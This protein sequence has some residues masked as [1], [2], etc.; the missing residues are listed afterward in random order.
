MRTTVLSLFYDESDLSPPTGTALEPR[1]GCSGDLYR[2]DRLTGRVAHLRH[3]TN[4]TLTYL[5][6]ARDGS[7][8]VSAENCGR[9][10]S[11]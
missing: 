6:A 8:A 3:D 5:A 10:T 7:Y 2:V 11:S 9:P 1:T 4:L